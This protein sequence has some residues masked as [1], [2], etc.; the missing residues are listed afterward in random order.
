MKPSNVGPYPAVVFNRAIEE[1]IFPSTF[2]I[3]KFI[4]FFKKGDTVE[5]E[6]YRPFSVLSS[7]SEDFEKRLYQR[8][9]NFCERKQLFTS[10]QFGFRSKNHVQMR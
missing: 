8:M 4:P 2:K 1:C 5:L 3:A 7:L 9:I 6:N 10:S